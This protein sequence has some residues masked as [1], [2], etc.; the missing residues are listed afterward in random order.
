MDPNA[1]ETIVTCTMSGIVVQYGVHAVFYS[2]F[3]SRLRIL[4][5]VAETIHDAALMAAATRGTVDTKCLQNSSCSN[6]QRET[7]N[8]TKP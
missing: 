5:S 3:G 1:N 7:Y 6:I 2:E 8:H 4:A